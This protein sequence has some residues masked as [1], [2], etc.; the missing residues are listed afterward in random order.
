MVIPIL[1]KCQF[2]LKQ[3]PD[4]W[5]KLLLLGLQQNIL[6]YNLTISDVTQSKYP[7]P[8]LHYHIRRMVRLAPYYLYLSW[9]ILPPGSHR[10]SSAPGDPHAAANAV[11][12]QCYATRRSGVSVQRLA[13]VGTWALRVVGHVEL[14]T[15]WHVAEGQRQI[16]KQPIQAIYSHINK[17]YVH[18]NRHMTALGISWSSM[19][20]L[21]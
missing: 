9:D 10:E 18:I 2:M 8:C 7:I 6:I 19:L 12:D 21:H 11:H 13:H 5:Y 20:F 16:L 17:F 3:S 4:Y 14:A 1:V 15:Q